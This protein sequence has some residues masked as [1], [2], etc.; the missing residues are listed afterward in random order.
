MNF[1]DFSNFIGS[2]LDN[3]QGKLKSNE[4]MLKIINNKQRNAL[5]T[6]KDIDSIYLQL[7]KQARR[8][9]NIFYNKVK[10]SSSSGE[11]LLLYKPNRRWIKFWVSNLG[12]VKEGFLAIVVE[13]PALSNNIEER[14]QLF[15][16]NYIGKVDNTPGTLVQDIENIKQQISSKSGSARTG[17]NKTLIELI[18]SVSEGNLN[19]IAQIFE[20]DS[21]YA[22][23]GMGRR[24][25]ALSNKQANQKVA[26]IIGEGSETLARRSINNTIRNIKNV[27]LK[28]E[29]I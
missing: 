1:K 29:L 19:R 18:R 13:S 17:S 9:L 12:D 8:R 7:Y 6:K 4:Q 3:F 24:N 10:K 2:A 22:N 27:E 21:E 25:K 15:A 5:Y 14:I 28:G 23:S 20:K 11:G 26:K 16:E